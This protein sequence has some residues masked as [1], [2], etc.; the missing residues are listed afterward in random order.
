MQR[1]VDVRGNVLRLNNIDR[2][3][4]SGTTFLF[5]GAKGSCATAF[6]SYGESE[7]HFRSKSGLNFANDGRVE[8]AWGR[9]RKAHG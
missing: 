2:R 5:Y 6:D 7:E 9:G 4:F 3:S 1:G 8:S